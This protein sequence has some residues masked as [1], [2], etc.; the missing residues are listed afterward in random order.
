MIYMDLPLFHEL[1]K[2]EMVY[3]DL[4]LKNSELFNVNCEVPMLL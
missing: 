2:Q 1:F 4:S 3:M